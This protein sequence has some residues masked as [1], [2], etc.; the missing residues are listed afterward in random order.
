MSGTS[1][2]VNQPAWLVMLWVNITRM[3]TALFT[4]L[5]FAWRKISLCAYHCSMGRVTLAPLTVIHPLRCVIP[6]CAWTKAPRDCCQTLIKTPLIFAATMMILS[7]NQLY[8]PRVFLICWS[9]VL[10]ASPL[11]W[12]PTW[13]RTIWVRLLMRVSRKSK[14]LRSPSQN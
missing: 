9:M 2:T 7:K 11:V 6:K 3:V 14:I 12:P 5:W 10:A 4:T 1:H 8:C 13:H